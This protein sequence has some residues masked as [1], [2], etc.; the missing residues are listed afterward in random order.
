MRVGEEIGNGIYKCYS[1]GIHV[2]DFHHSEFMEFNEWASK[3]S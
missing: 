2:G 1:Q 3:H